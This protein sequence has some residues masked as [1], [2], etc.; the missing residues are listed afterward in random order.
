MA[1]V[2]AV[3][4]IPVLGLL[5]GTPATTDLRAF[6]ETRGAAAIGVIAAAAIGVGLRSGSSG[7]P[8]VIDVADLHLVLLSPLPR[9]AFLRPRLWRLAKYAGLAG[10]AV[11]AVIAGTAAPALGANAF[12][13]TGAGAGAGV[14]IAWCGLA[15]AVAAHSRGTSGRAAMFVACTLVGIAV[16]NFVAGPTW[17]PFDVFGEIALLPVRRNIAL[18]TVGGVISIAAL[19]GAGRLVTGLDVEASAQR[20]AASQG[21]LGGVALHDIRALLLALHS[22]PGENFR[23]APWAPAPGPV[24]WLMWGRAWRGLLR[25][26]GIR[27]ARFCI[28]GVVT[29]LAASASSEIPALIAVAVAATYLAALE[30][31][32]PIAQ[33]IDRPTRRAGYPTSPAALYVRMIGGPAVALVAVFAMAAA[34]ALALGELEVGLRLA[35]TAVPGALAAAASATFAL[36]RGRPTMETLAQFALDPT[37]IGVYQ[38]HLLPSAG[39][40]AA[41]IALLI[42]VGG[43]V[44]TGIVAGAAVSVAAVILMLGATAYVAWRGE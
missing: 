7:G 10:G 13:A 23:L 3:V 16:I 44:A 8:F 32:E 22:R 25:T 5:A 11:G 18:A 20:S 29:G 37:G 27:V 35:G 17:L 40:A 4:F 33:E 31:I 30:A 6:A 15:A 2:A 28:C 19:A 34:T 12:A 36:A 1:I 41:V 42:P 24:R 9:Q 39:A 14:A 21:A 26:P 43:S 38:Y